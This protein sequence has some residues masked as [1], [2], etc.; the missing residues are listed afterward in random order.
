LVSNNIKI[1]IFR[2]IILPAVLC[3]CGTWSLALRVEDGMRVFEI[4]VLS[5][6][7]GE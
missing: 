5:K 7:T 6:L 3:G 2:N 1:K 4:R